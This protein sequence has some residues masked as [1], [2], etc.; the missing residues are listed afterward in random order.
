M[1][2]LLERRD[3]RTQDSSVSASGGDSGASSSFA[4]GVVLPAAP[5]LGEL[6]PDVGE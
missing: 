6:V 4:S 2:R 3:R 5:T 1:H